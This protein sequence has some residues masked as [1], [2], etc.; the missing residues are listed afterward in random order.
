M[1]KSRKQTLLQTRMGEHD[2]NELY[3]CEQ[4]TEYMKP[5]NVEKLVSLTNKDMQ[6][7]I[8]GHGASSSAIPTKGRVGSAIGNRSDAPQ[9]NLRKR[10]EQP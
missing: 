9:S 4:S 10:K 3:R 5:V 1:I 6:H 8:M 7:S 2:Q